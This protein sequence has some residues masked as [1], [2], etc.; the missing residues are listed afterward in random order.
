MAVKKSE[1]GWLWKLAKG[2]GIAAAAGGAVYL[3]TGVG[4][5]KNS[6]VIP[7][8]IEDQLD[9]LADALTKQFGEGWIKETEKVLMAAVPLPLKPLVAVLR[10]AQETG[11][12]AGWDWPQTRAEAAK[13]HKER[14]SAS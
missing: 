9:K 12:V 5:K 14:G 7:D 1:Y 4:S 2:A 11:A 3:A 6:P 8:A 10:T 13:L